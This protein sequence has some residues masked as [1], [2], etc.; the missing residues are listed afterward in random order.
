M[1]KTIHFFVKRNILYL[2]IFLLP[3]AGFSTVNYTHITSNQGL[4][5]SWVRAIYQDSYGFM[6]FGTSGA[7]N[8]Y[9]GINCEVFNIGNRNVNAILSKDE[10]Y[11][12]ICTDIGVY[13]FNTFTNTLHANDILTHVS[14]LSAVQLYDSVFLFGTNHGIY[15]YSTIDSSLHLSVIPRNELTGRSNYINTLYIDSNKNLWIGTKNGLFVQAYG[16]SIYHHYSY[17]S[18][19]PNISH[20]EVYAI[21]EHISG[22]ILIGSLQGGLDVLH[23]AVQHPYSAHVS[24][25]AQGTVMDIAIDTA[26]NIWFASGNGLGYIAYAD[27]GKPSVSIQYYKNNPVDKQSISDN[28][29]YSLFI[30]YMG[31][32]WIGTLGSGVTLLSLRAKKFYTKTVTRQ[33]ANSLLSNLINVVFE[34]DDYLWIGTELGLSKYNKRT[35]TFTHYQHQQ[36]NPK[37]LRSNAIFAITKDSY[38]KL[39]IG[40]WAGGISIYDYKTDSFSHIYPDGTNKT[41]NNENVF[42]IVE[43]HNKN[44]WIGTIGGGINVFDRHTQQFRYYRFDYTDSSTVV[45]DFVNHIIVTKDNTKFFSASSYSIVEYDEENNSFLRHYL[46]DTISA[47]TDLNYSICLFEDSKGQIW[48]GTYD[49]LYCFN[50]ETKKFTS[51]LK[52]EPNINKTIAAITEDT[53]QNLW[54]STSHGIVKFLQGVT[55]P[56]SLDFLRFSIADGIAGNEGK[57]RAIFRNPVTNTIYIGSSQGLTYFNP[58]EIILNTYVPNVVFT[59]FKQLNVTPNKTHTFIPLPINP[60]TIDKIELSYKNSSFV[61]EFAILN[62][63]SSETNRYI[64][65]LEGYDSDWIDA[66]HSRVATY[67]NI[68]PGTYFFKV[69]ASNNDGIWSQEPIRLTIVI[70]PPWWNTIYFR[71]FVVCLVLLLLYLFFKIRFAFIK[72][73]KILLEQTVA[74]RTQELQKANTV[75]AEKQEEIS[76]QNNEIYTH[77]NNLEKLIEVRTIELVKALDKAK[78]NDRLK[79]AFLN[80]ISHEIRT[81]MNAIMGFTQLLKDP[82]TTEEEKKKFLQIILDSSSQLLSIISDIIN[83]AKIETGKEYVQNKHFNINSVLRSLYAQ[84]NLFVKDSELTLLH[85]FALPDADA[86]ICSD[87]TKIIEIISNLIQNAIKFTDK[88]QVRFGYEIQDKHTLTFFVED[89]GIGIDP[90][91]QMIIFERFRQA[92]HANKASEKGTG[93]GLSIA[94]AYVEMLH[95][96]IWVESEVGAGSRFCFT[97]PY[98]TDSEQLKKEHTTPVAKIELQKGH[99]SILIAED[100]EYNFILIQELLKT[101]KFSITRAVNGIEAIEHCKKQ[102]F[103]L[104]LMDIKMPELDGI[105]ASKRIKQMYPLMPIIAQ[106]AYSD[107]VDMQKA[108][109]AGVSDF[110]IKPLNIHQL[111]QI[112]D[113][114]LT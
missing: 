45:S 42:S 91:D 89:T 71:F 33:S 61:I 52:S 9:N 97:I 11:L 74:K 57:S 100:E 112:L 113:I 41:I 75:L 72:K 87:E 23:N 26:H 8:R 29:L 32:V 67:T 60:N 76:R 4:S 88:G 84:Y 43:D 20:D 6:W 68:P 114:Y 73:Q 106:S 44:M 70:V 34:E 110:L 56:E 109:D 59:A 27:F 108:Y 46:P 15:R 107:E 19:S 24:I 82:D 105:E 96:V 12:F 104:V 101:Y 14:V 48:V 53:N 69:H 38:G 7:L 86:M 18:T 2:C 58:D 21:T 30:D 40:T 16:D 54:L 28:A 78:E 95:G 55:V 3:Y 83:I 66:E 77:R 99:K 13:T 85:E 35:K 37:S 93:L 5:H 102:E 63:V 47:N 50:R 80:N 79:T 25:L 1:C 103:D 31:D 39:W 49:G 36:D 10:H 92:K 65:M 94:K 62:Y 98:V 111:I 90:K 51:F 22:S 81:P 64:Y 17:S